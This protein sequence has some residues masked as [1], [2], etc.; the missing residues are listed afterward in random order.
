MFRHA[1]TLPR[2]FLFF[3]LQL[4]PR[5]HSNQSAGWLHYRQPFNAAPSPRFNLHRKYIGKGYVLNHFC[6]SEFAGWLLILFRKRA[7]SSKLQTRDSVAN[8]DKSSSRGSLYSIACT[9]ICELPHRI[10]IVFNTS[11][12]TSAH[13]KIFTDPQAKLYRHDSYRMKA[14][15][16]IRSHPSMAL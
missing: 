11:Y 1:R 2:R 15:E 5:D 12:L 7:F 3:L 14:D 13:H 8:E 10:H 6:G 9:E 16:S 4:T